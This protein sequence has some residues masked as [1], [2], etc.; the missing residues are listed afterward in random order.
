MKNIYK[1]LLPV[2]MFV[3]S[4]L[5][6]FTNVF[7]QATF[8]TK[9]DFAAG[10]FPYSV[11]TA[12]LN[13]DGLPDMVVTNSDDNTISVLMNTTVP[14]A[15]TA[16]YSAKTDF[17]TGFNPYS[18]AIGDLNGDGKPDIAVANRFSG[19]VSV[20]L[21]TTTTG[22]L[23][24]TFTDNMEFNANSFT[25]SVSIADI[26]GDGKKDLVVANFSSNNVSVYL[27]TTAPGAVIPTFSDKVDS[28]PQIHQSR[29]LL[30]T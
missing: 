10:N 11:A 29:F 17:S 7:A 18:V 22:S 24:P 6:L 25:I 4:F 8:S 2:K 15:T 3:I 21:N 16:S 9:T 23:T 13:G 19:T 12:D 1:E 14:G 5:L 20:L 26:N 28:Q 27:N 30:M